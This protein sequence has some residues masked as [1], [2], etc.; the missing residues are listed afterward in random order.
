MTGIQKIDFRSIFIVASIEKFC[1]VFNVLP[2]HSLMTVR[3]TL[4]DMIC[5]PFYGF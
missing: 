3:E 5:K 4:I 2:Y 1:H